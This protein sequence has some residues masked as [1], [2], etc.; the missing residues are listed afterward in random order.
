MES[1][2]QKAVDCLGEVETRYRELSWSRFFLDCIISETMATEDAIT[3]SSPVSSRRR[4]LR[5]I[6]LQRRRF[7]AESGT[8]DCIQRSLRVSWQVVT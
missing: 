7:I 8:Q 6:Y 5:P 2:S 4:A 1:L 3:T